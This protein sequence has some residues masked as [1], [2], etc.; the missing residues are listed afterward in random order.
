MDDLRVSIA[1]C[2]RTILVRLQADDA[3]SGDIA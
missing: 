1:A 3:V 2:K